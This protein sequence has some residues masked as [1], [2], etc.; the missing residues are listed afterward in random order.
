MQPIEIQPIPPITPKEKPELKVLSTAAQW[1]TLGELLSSPDL[2][3][4]QEAKRFAEQYGVSLRDLGF[5]KDT[6]QKVERHAQLH[7]EMKRLKEQMEPLI[8]M[9]RKD[10]SHPIIDEFLAQQGRI[11]LVENEDGSGG[12]YFAKIG[13][14]CRYI[15]KPADEDV[16]GFNNRKGVALPISI[17]ES[18]NFE[19]SPYKA[20]Q[21]DL[22]MYDLAL[23]M[24]IQESVPE[25][26]MMIVENQGFY[27]HF[28]EVDDLTK[29]L[30]LDTGA[31]PDDQKLCTVQRFV[32]ESKTLAETWHDILASGKG[33]FDQTSFE[34]LNILFWLSFESDGHMGNILATVKGI[35]SEGNKI[36][37]LKKI[38]S[39]FSFPK[40]DEYSGNADA[41]MSNG[42]ERLSE[43]AKQLIQNTDPDLIVKRMGQL[44]YDQEHQTAMQR[45]VERLKTLAQEDLTIREIDQKMGGMDR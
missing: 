2:R 33:S 15:V 6:A 43:R 41:Y 18:L 17:F 28:K 5:F 10:G 35:D 3:E 29:K 37:A 44:G 19:F 7:F 11:T 42:Q 26:A 22:M 13:G 39:T 20:P 16:C 4:Y 31:G 27:D 40:S 30:A 34:N 32:K 23:I 9:T 45:R 8:E 14:E 24:G 1:Y 21:N 25:T 12:S 36:Y 38:D